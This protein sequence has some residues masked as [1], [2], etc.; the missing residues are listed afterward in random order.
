WSLTQ[1]ESDRVASGRCRPEA[2]TDPYVLAFEHTVPQIRD[3]LRT[4]KPNARSARR[5]ADNAGAGGGDGPSSSTARGC[6]GNA[7]SASDAEP[8]RGTSTAPPSC[9]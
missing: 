2:P 7:T 4:C 3:S 9:P 8:P 1:R 5:P 6:G